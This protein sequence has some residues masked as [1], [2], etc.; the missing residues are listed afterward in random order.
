[1]GKYYDQS[2]REILHNPKADV[3]FGPIEG[4]LRQHTKSREH[5]FKP[6]QTTLSGYVEIENVDHLSFSEQYHTFQSFGYA[7]D[8]STATTNAQNKY[9]GDTEKLKENEAMTVY[10]QSNKMIKSK[11]N[12]IRKRLRN[13]DPSDI[14]GYN[15][16]WAPT[17]KTKEEEIKYQKDLEKRKEEWKLTESLRKKRKIDKND[18]N[19]EEEFDEKKKKKKK[20]KKERGVF[21]KKKKKKKKK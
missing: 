20:K 19:E 11:K 15:G 12:A 9:I 13:E 16:P 2:T 10:N 17:Y 4:P 18:K 8:P 21:K 7:V 14:D 3:L 6:K 1:M 5:E